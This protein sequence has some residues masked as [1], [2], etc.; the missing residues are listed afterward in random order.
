MRLL[1]HAEVDY[2][3][4]LVVDHIVAEMAGGATVPAMNKEI[5]MF[6]AGWRWAEEAGLV[7]SLLRKKGLRY[8]KTAERP[9]FQTRE[10]IE[11]NISRG[12]PTDRASGA[13][14]LLVFGGE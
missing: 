7:F 11:R 1:S 5:V 8:P 3:G 2:R 14:A 6:S 4:R 10:E 13:L 9:A 12:G